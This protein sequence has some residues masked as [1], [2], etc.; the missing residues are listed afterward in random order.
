MPF[1]SNEK[2]SFFIIKGNTFLPKHSFEKKFF[3]V[4]KKPKNTIKNKK[5]G[6]YKPPLHNLLNQD[7]FLMILA[8]E[9][10]SALATLTT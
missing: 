1:N 10:P 6:S 4:Y 7:Y 2:L 9:T 5:R 8:T 3:Y